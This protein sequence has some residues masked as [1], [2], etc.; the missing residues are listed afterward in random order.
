MTEL[1]SSQAHF[2]GGHIAPGPLLTPGVGSYE[3]RDLLRYPDML[4]RGP[5][6]R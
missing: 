3:T 4:Q 2:R 6:A 5:N 1:G